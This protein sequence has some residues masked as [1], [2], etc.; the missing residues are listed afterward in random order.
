MITDSKRGSD[1]LKVFIASRESTCDACGAALGRHA[2]ITLQ[3]DKGVR[4]LTCADLDHLVFLPSGDT[5]LTRRARKHSRLAA[6][7]L[8]WSRTRGRYERQGL[9]VENEAIEQAERECEADAPQRELRR[10]HATMR[11]EELDQDYI[12][13]FANRVRELYPQCPADREHRIAEH[14]CRKYSRRVGRSAAAKDLAPET[15]RLAVLA[16]IRHTETNYD[17]WLSAGVDR[18]EARARVW[19]NVAGIAHQWE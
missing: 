11:R 15:I 13:R 10:A 14:A 17:T 19:E 8:Q 16:H 6:V 9:L 3:E 5:A 4:C 12:R 2:W 7:V 18:A 1:G